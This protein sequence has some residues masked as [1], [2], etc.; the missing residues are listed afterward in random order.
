VLL[1]HIVGSVVAPDSV[2]VRVGDIGGH[3]LRHR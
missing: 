3:H 2:K 1:D